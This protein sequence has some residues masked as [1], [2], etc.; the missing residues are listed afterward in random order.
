MA[1]DKTI[2]A[3]YRI[4]GVIGLLLLFLMSPS[5]T[6]SD[7]A[8]GET[9]KGFQTV[10]EQ[11]AVNKALEALIKEGDW[12]TAHKVV[13]RYLDS[14]IH[15]PTFFQNAIHIFIYLEAYHKAVALAQLAQDYYPDHAP[16][17]YYDAYLS[18]RE[19]HCVQ[20][21]RAWALYQKTSHFPVKESQDA[22]FA[23]YCGL[24]TT[25]QL[26]ITSTIGREDRLATAFGPNE[27]A[28]DE[29]STLGQICAL[30]IV[31][32]PEGRLFRVAA[33]PP[34]RNRMILRYHSIVDKRY[35][36]RYK[37]EVGL[38]IGQHIGG[39]E[40]HSS[41]FYTS[42]YHRPV[43]DRQIRW[44][45]GLTTFYVPP[46]AQDQAYSSRT[47]YIEWRVSDRLSANLRQD[48]SLRYQL[49]EIEVD[50]DYSS[51]HHS[52]LSQS[53][54]WHI[55]NRQKASFFASIEQIKP[56]H[57]DEYGKQ[58][59]YGYGIGYQF[60][61]KTLWSLELGYE[62]S[63]YQFAK[64]LPFLENPHR[65]IEKQYNL[66]ISKSLDKAKGIVPF[67]QISRALRQSDNPRQHGRRT[68]VS[69]GLSFHY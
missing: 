56:P 22:A 30:D 35:S 17:Y 43:A 45:V 47:P 31:T 19:G 1:G 4:G 63:Y 52:Y 26:F 67:V 11:I 55:T 46:F 37:G 39:Y 66:K 41:H 23:D 27:F 54:G 59:R 24:L 16:F 57:D 44:R 48:F 14:P 40:G 20:A 7:E 2:M 28:A 62:R 29:G 32:C 53:Y 5:V 42:L 69:A 58:D 49:Q 3:C 38:E 61:S 50:N 51:N 8:G 12:Q 33:P 10:Q 6:L 18:A 34:P 13:S 15:N 36:W 65:I 68:S 21:R 60:Q 64:T 25:H 9:V